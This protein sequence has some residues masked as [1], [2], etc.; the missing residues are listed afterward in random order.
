MVCHGMNKLNFLTTI[1]QGLRKL[2][3]KKSD[4]FFG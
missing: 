1:I 2:P 4:I 3:L